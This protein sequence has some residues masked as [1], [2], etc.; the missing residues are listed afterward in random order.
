MKYHLMG[1]RILTATVLFLILA[2]ANVWADTQS[3]LVLAVGYR[4]FLLAAPLFLYFGL[5][6]GMRMALGLGVVSIALAMIAANS[7]SLGFFALSMAVSGYITK[8]VSSHSSQGAADNKVS[9]N[10]GSLFA[11]LLV[12]GISSKE[13]LLPLSVV[14]LA[15]A[16]YLSFKLDW[17]KLGLADLQTVAQKTK[18]PKN[19][20]SLL[21]W[22]L[23]GIA[24]GIKLTG[25]FTILPQ[26]LIYK[27]GSLPSWFGSLIVINSLGV[28]F[29]QHRVL[30]FLDRTNKKMTL[31][32][33]LTAMALLALPAV[34]HV[35]GI[36]SAVIWISLLTFGE[37]ALS[38]YDKFS[39][40]AGYLFEKELMVGVGSF[41]TVA[42][43]RDFSNHIYLSGLIGFVCLL[44][45]SMHSFKM[46]DFRALFLIFGSN[47]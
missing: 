20:I 22:S 7:L 16:L 2:Q 25:V 9:L 3:H 18:H 23:I 39:R 15:W 46:K 4:T 13:I 36:A 32:F 29:F 47:R 37:C 41:I 33:S 14:L 43:S 11:G 6:Y 5:S 35:E 34:M 26:Y 12:M 31:L 44:L 28:I 21:R 24:T 10:I 27:S 45:G 19:F 30:N 42:L 1:I 40:Q 8:F 38:H 17:K